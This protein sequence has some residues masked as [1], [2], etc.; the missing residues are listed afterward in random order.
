MLDIIYRERDLEDERGDRL[1]F[2]QKIFSLV[3][4][5]VGRHGFKEFNC[6]IG[7]P[8]ACGSFS[9]SFVWEGLR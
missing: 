8:V 4:R 7:R 1:V 2:M 6:I 9:S 5:G 3:P